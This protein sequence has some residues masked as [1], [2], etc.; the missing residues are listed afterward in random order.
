MKRNYDAVFFD[1][2]GTIADT[3]KGIFASADYAAEKLG[4][5]LPDDAGHRYFMGP[6]LPESFEVIFGLKGDDAMNAVRKYRE[7]YTAGGMF[8][9]EFYPGMLEFLDALKKNGIKTAVTSSKPE[10]FV[11]QILEHFGIA[12]RI[13]HIACPHGDGMPES[14]CS[15]IT[16]A[17]KYFKIDRSRALMLSDRYLDMQGAAQAGVDG[18]GALWGYGSEDEL[19]KAGAKFTAKSVCDVSSLV[20]SEEKE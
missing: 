3:S 13:D 1:F 16:R 17:L 11:S 7:Y 8:E 6:P 4:L 10:M 15:L 20:F 19:L 14:K 5:P 12:D 2:D 18:C 9:L